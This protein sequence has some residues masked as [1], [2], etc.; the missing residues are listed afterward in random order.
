M[1]SITHQKSHSPRDSFPNPVSRF[2]KRT[3]T[4][5]TKP[6]DKLSEQH[7]IRNRKEFEEAVSCVFEEE[8]AHKSLGRKSRVNEDILLDN[9]A[10]GRPVKSKV[11][12]F[13]ISK[14]LGCL[15]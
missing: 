2:P 14:K 10:F 5:P 13:I 3:L 12:M 11:Y 1:E 4:M 8:I 6:V 15:K 7:P 9:H